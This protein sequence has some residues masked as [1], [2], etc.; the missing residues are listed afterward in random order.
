MKAVIVKEI[1]KAAVADVPE[2]SQRPDYVK[3]KTVAVAVNPSNYP[4]TPIRLPY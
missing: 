2:Q 3:I 1:G 4:Q